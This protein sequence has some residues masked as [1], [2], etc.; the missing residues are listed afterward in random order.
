[1]YYFIIKIA[2]N[3]TADSFKCTDFDPKVIK[4]KGFS[5]VKKPKKTVET[6]RNWKEGQYEHHFKSSQLQEQVIWIIN[7]SG[8]LN[9]LKWNEWEFMW[10]L[11]SQILSQLNRREKVIDSKA[12][13]EPEIDWGATFEERAIMF[14]SVIMKPKWELSLEEFKFALSKLCVLCSTLGYIYKLCNDTKKDLM[15]FLTKNDCLNSIESSKFNSLKGFLE[16]PLT[17]LNDMWVVWSVI[18]FKD[19]EHDRWTTNVNDINKVEILINYFMEN[20]TNL[21]RN[22]LKWVLDELFRLSVS[23]VIEWQE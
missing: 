15:L 11:L 4:E 3:S 18:E 22:E 17:Y 12:C 23:I 7:K 21:N 16:E 8:D 5:I 1:M 9:S 6:K 14:I 13:N 20:S 10:Q 2:M 19:I